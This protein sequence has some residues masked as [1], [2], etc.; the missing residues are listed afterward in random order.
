MGDKCNW[1][2][3]L[4][5]WFED[6]RSNPDAI[7]SRMAW[8]F[9][10]NEDRDQKLKK[11]YQDCCEAALEGRLAK[12]QQEPA[13]RLSLILLLD[14]FPRNLF[15]GTPRAFSGDDRA[16]L[17]CLSGIAAGIDRELSPIERAFF[18]MTLQHTEDVVTQRVSVQK[19]KSLAEEQ[20]SVAVYSGFATYAQQ[21]LDIVEEFGRFP[22]RN[23][24]LGRAS[25]KEEID[26]LESGG[27]RFGQ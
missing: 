12:W 8:W 7:G 10:A 6:T 21:H 26:Y 11:I 27:A 1:Q 4:D 23:E 19:F 18:Y 9:F 13:S 2:E 3:V 25:S 24:I 22:H 17:L 5:T 16:A 14:Q 15:R 20:K